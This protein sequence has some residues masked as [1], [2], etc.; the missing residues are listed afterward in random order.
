MQS[1]QEALYQVY[2]ACLYIGHKD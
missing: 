1:S 2:T